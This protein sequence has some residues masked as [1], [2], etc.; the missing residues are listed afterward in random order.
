MTS[1][2]I[3]LCS[4]VT[5]YI[6]RWR[7]CCPL[8]ISPQFCCVAN[9]YSPILVMMAATYEYAY[10][11]KVRHLN[12]HKMSY[13]WRCIH[14]N[15]RI[16]DVQNRRLPNG[17]TATPTH[18][19]VCPNRE[20]ASPWSLQVRLN[21][22]LKHMLLFLQNKQRTESW[23]MFFHWIVEWFCSCAKHL[24]LKSYI[25]LLRHTEVPA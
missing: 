6:S 13:I 15:R 21:A 20:F 14:Q 19:I 16:R 7:F 3:D 10:N 24:W 9:E 18:C 17:Q 2:N 8:E 4:W 1:H 12:I 22:V 23:P 25:F 5:L 11:A